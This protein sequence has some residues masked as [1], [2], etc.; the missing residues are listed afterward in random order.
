MSQS[1]SSGHHIY[2]PTKSSTFKR[3]SGF[4]WTIK[5]GDGSRASGDVGTDKVVIGGATATTQA[6]EMA[7]HVSTELTQDT[8]IDGLVG[9]S[10]SSINTG[11]AGHFPLIS[12]WFSNA[13]VIKTVLPTAQKTFFDSIKS[14]LAAPLFTADLKK[15]KPGCYDFGFIDPAKHTDQIVFTNVNDSRGFWQFTGSGFA[16]GSGPFKQLNINAIAG[17]SQ[18]NL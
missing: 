16:V 8:E 11:K 7:T 18:K 4:S 9:L 3:L 1:S 13:N 14:S 2:D 12:N 17:E 5:Y 6:V 15:G 10:F